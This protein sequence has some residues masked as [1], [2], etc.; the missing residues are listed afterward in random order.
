M[1]GRD[2]VSWP[3]ADDTVVN[4]VDPPR[5]PLSPATRTFRLRRLALGAAVALLALPGSAAAAVTG[6]AVVLSVNATDHEI[7][8]VDA[9]HDVDAYAFDGSARTLELGDTI[10]YGQ[11]GARIAGV[12]V[13][14]HA[15]ELSY[16][17][18][19]VRTEGK[20]VVLRLGDGKTVALATSTRV[21]PQTNAGSEI[22]AHAA[23]A[24]N[25]TLNSDALAPGATVLVT[26]TVSAGGA[27]AITITLPTLDATNIEY[28]FHASAGEQAVDDVDGLAGNGTWTI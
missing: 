23:S 9:S 8:V 13:T 11:T 2:R 15:R 14:G 27:T 28:D 7:Q 19:V 18:S 16:Y 22:L 24:P 5:L 12:R 1:S 17:A 4:P 21:R 3:A 6:R 26:E 10:A 20:H 25:A